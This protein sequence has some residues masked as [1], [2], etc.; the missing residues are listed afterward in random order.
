MK[1]EQRLAF[2]KSVHAAITAGVIDLAGICDEFGVSLQTA[3]N[4]FNGKAAPVNKKRRL[5][6]MFRLDQL[7][8]GDE[9]KIDRRAAVIATREKYL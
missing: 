1:L 8:R 9:Y 7:M 3:K 5:R 6:I 4:W 2:A